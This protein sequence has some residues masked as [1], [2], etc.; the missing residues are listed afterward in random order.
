MSNYA[1]HILQCSVCG[2]N[3]NVCAHAFESVLSTQELDC[4]TVFEI[5]H[6]IAEK[7]GKKGINKEM[8]KKREKY[9]SVKMS[10]MCGMCMRFDGE[11]DRER[12]WKGVH[13]KPEN[14]RQCIR[15]DKI[16]RKD[17]KTHTQ[18]S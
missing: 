12:E 13:K 1:K 4:F 17:N 11:R 3:V 10:E 16:I 8:R 18:T 15:F 6:R 9:F 7:W 5:D 14:L 2:G